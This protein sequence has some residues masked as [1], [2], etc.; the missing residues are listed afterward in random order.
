MRYPSQAALKHHLSIPQL[1]L[2][3]G[4][5]FAVTAVQA[6]EPATP[7]LI[8]VQVNQVTLEAHGP[9]QAIVEYLGQQSGG[10]YRVLRDGKESSKGQLSALPGFD[11]WGA[12]KHYFVADFSQDSEA[13]S[14]VIEAELGG[15]KAVSAPVVVQENALFNATASSLLAYFHASRNTNPKDRHLRIYDSQRYADVWG[16]WNDAGGDEGKYLSHLSYANFFNPQ[17]ASMV[18]WILAKTATTAPQLYR[19]AGLEGK[20]RDEAFWGADYLHRILDRQGYFYTTVFD[21]WGTDNAERMVTGFEGLDGKYSKSYKSAFR[22][23]GGMAIAALAR[24]SILAK[25]SGV[26]GEFSATIY[27]VDAKRAFDH[28]QVHNREYC[29]DG[30]ENIIDDYT[31][32]MAATELYH[33]TH[34]QKYLAAARLHAD[35]LSARQTAD[36]WF[37][38][39][40]GS[41]PYYH[42]V[43][44]GLPILSLVYYREIETDA[45]RMSRAQKTISTALDAQLRLDS[46]VVNPYNYARQTFRTY[47]KGQLSKQVYE[48]FF[49]P[50]DNETGYWWQGESARLSSLSTAA[51]LGGRA[52]APQAQGAFGIKPN[53]AE[54]AQ[55]QVDWTLGRNPYGMSMLHGFGVRNPPDAESA[56]PMTKGGVSNGIT[57]ATDSSTARGI[58]FAP[59]PDENQWRWVEQWLPHSAWLLLNAVTMAR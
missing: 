13:G 11:E 6:A 41:R 20:V 27:L 28:L 52:I 43:E 48:G 37:I 4:S 47:D 9:K 56:G 18:T 44:A 23:G 26:H 1:T 10:S 34:E 8:S 59:G 17:Q 2:L 29:Y 46:K 38:S 53:L 32:L 24:A 57:G 35:K 58:V 31:A 12:G 5:L 45:A 50:H 36:G 54:F 25:N 3:L 30:K 49:M 33:A 39:D 15:E 40:N 19:K 7:A 55:N 51:I 14:Y 16:G 21:K 42:G 22:A